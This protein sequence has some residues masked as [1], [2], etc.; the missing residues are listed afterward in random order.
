MSVG[1]L[2]DFGYRKKRL[3]W[4]PDCFVPKFGFKRTQHGK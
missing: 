1:H 3:L 2:V 4:L